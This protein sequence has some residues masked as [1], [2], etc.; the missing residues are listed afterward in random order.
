V[1]GDVLKHIPFKI[2]MKIRKSL[3][4]MLGETVSQ[5]WD[6]YAKKFRADSGKHLGE[7]WNEPEVIGFDVPP[8]QIVSSLDQM[9]I[10]PF[11]GAPDVILE[12]GPG[13]G[14]FTDILLPKCQKVIAADTS[15]T[16]LSLLRERFKDNPKLECVLL[17]GQ[18]LRP[19]H[20]KSVDAAFSFDVFVHLE[21]WDIF[22]Y[23]SE[24]KRV[25]KPG[26]KAL[27]HHGNSFSELGW[28]RFV[29]DTAQQLNVPKDWGTFS[30]M[31]PAVFKELA[32]RSGLQYTECITD[33]VRRDG[34][35]LLKS[36]EG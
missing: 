19:I 32:E 29:A 10:Q 15:P 13:G 36:P 23:L 34:I 20:D 24:L 21:Q 31:T 5:G 3:A 33:I 9:I 17:D 22:N 1:V 35:S 25:L 2:R 16:M 4:S 11:L 30:F 27:I 26:G 12:I 6:N 28:K 8:G 14:R 7:E 18:G